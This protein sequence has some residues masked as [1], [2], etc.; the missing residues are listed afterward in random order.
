MISPNLYYI[1]WSVYWC[2]QLFFSSFSL[3][4][5]SP[6]IKLMTDRIVV[7]DGLYR[8]WAGINCG[9]GSRIKRARLWNHR[10]NRWNVKCCAFTHSWNLYICIV[11]FAFSPPSL[12]IMPTGDRKSWERCRRRVLREGRELRT[13]KWCNYQYYRNRR[14]WLQDGSPGHFRWFDQR[15]RKMSWICHQFISTGV[16]FAGYYAFYMLWRY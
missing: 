4:C 12:M 6:K 5:F 7:S 8:S 2:P 14:S 15:K 11:S 3:V 1:F 16:S 10:R 13:G 9:F